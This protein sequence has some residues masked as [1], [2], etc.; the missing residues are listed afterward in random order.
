[1]ARH[2]AAA[3]IVAVGALAVAGCGGQTSR[4]EQPAVSP[5]A[6]S[7]AGLAA[8]VRVLRAA[9]AQVNTN[10]LMG[11]PRLRRATT[12]YASDLERSSLDNLTRNRQLDFAAAAVAGV[13]DQCFEQLEAMRPIPA[14]AGQ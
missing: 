4:G 1:V 11:T 2:S 12:R 5:R 10:T 8:D 14:L 13:C 9:A 7:L 3:A 6:R